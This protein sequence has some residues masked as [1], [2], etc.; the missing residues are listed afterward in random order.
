[1]LCCYK[2]HIYF[3]VI[4]SLLRSSFPC[5]QFVSNLNIPSEQTFERKYKLETAC[6][7]IYPKI[8]APICHPARLLRFICYVP[9]GLKTLVVN[10]IHRPIIICY[11]HWSFISIAVGATSQC[12]LGLCYVTTGCFWKHDCVQLYHLYSF[13][14]RCQPKN[15]I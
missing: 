10:Y 6:C 11:M 5:N 8:C 7:V 2:V 13:L 14:F 1:M 4:N 12:L 3:Y 9:L 15:L